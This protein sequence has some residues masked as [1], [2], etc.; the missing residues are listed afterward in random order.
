[1]ASTGPGA[2][3][4]SGEAS[5][6][7]GLGP[8]LTSSPSRDQECRA[9]HTGG[10]QDSGHPGADRLWITTGNTEVLPE[11]SVPDAPPDLLRETCNVGTLTAHPERREQP[12]RGRGRP[13][14]GGGDL[15][16]TGRWPACRQEGEG[17][18]SGVQGSQPLAEAETTVSRGCPGPSMGSGAERHPWGRWVGSQVWSLERRQ[19]DGRGWMALRG[20]DRQGERR[21]RA[22]LFCPCSR[23]PRSL[24]QGPRAALPQ[25]PSQPGLSRCLCVLEL[26]NDI[27]GTGRPSV[28]AHSRRSK[29]ALHGELS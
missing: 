26:D 12:V 4:F 23:G 2:G 29:S 8:G 24:P 22:S 3:H 19:T 25:L 13:A 20:C 17:Q 10:Q 16:G 28:I 9:P 11:S 15:G 21:V 5:W 1:M 18:E 6:K 27:L 7:E 14:A